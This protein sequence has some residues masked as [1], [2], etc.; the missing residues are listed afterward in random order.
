MT[1]HG[2]RASSQTVG[3]RAVDYVCD[4]CGTQA[5]SMEGRRDKYSYGFEPGTGDVFA[6][7]VPEDCDEAV[8]AGV[9]KL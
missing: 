9:M 5:F 1:R 2:W 7:L 4:R 3:K 6:E 8:A